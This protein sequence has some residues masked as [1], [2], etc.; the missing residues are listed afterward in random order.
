VKIPSLQ[1]TQHFT[2]E[3]DRVL[4]LTVGIRLPSF[5]DDC[6]TNHVAYSR[7]VKLQVSMGFR[8]HQGGWSS[9]I[10]LQIIKGLP[11]P[12]SPMEVVLFLGV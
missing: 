8:E 7:Y 3:I 1:I 10:L 4:D 2:D 5:D 12:L 9:Q 11:C 6:Y